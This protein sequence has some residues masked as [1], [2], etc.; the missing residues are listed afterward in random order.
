MN[1]LFIKLIYYG[2]TQAPFNFFLHDHKYNT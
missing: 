2:K 1:I